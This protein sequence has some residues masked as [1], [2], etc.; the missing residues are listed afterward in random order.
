MTAGLR[1]RDPN[2]GVIIVEITDRLTRI[3]GQVYTGT[4]AGSI[5][6]PQF[7]LGSGFAV[8]QEPPPPNPNIA[9]IYR[10]PRAFVSGTTLSWDFPGNGVHPAVGAV[11][12]YGVF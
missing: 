10:F 9:N 6:V 2:T 12:Q 5:Q 3:L 1:V 11:I 8:I 4:T 7:A